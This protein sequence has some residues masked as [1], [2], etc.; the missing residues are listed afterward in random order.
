MP[1]P[2][3]LSL[4]LEISDAV[5]ERFDDREASFWSQVMRWGYALWYVAALGLLGYLAGW[6]LDRNAPRFQ[7]VGRVALSLFG[8]VVGAAIARAVVLRR[9]TGS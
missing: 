8:G 9:R 3:G 5:R 2:I 4:E 7:V 1:A 6:Q